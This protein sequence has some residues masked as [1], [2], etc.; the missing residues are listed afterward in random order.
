[1]R[2]EKVLK[3]K[4]EIFE[5]TQDL[6]RLK[7]VGYGT[8]EDSLRNLRLVEFIGL[9]PASHS[10]Y[11]RICDKVMRIGRHLKMGVGNGLPYEKFEDDVLDALNYLFYL[12]ILVSEEEEE[13]VAKK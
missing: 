10:V 9:M 13:G 11:V 5:K 8:E 2:V 3:L 12:L 6:T 7:G 1:M 4:E